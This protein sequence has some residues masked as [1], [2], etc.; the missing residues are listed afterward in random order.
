ME[1]RLFGLTMIDCRHLAF[2]L[3]EKNNLIH[4]FNRDMQM[5]GDWMKYF[6]SRHP[7][8]ALRKPEATFGA[9]AMGFN[10]SNVI[11]IF[12]F[13]KDVVDKH[14]LTQDRIY[15]SDET[16]ISINPKGHSK[17]IATGGKCQ[18]AALKSADRG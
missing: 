10:R 7:E 9:R 12:D 8:L 3:A 11:R 17:I 18:V 16:G 14:K 13:L 1:T 4:P 15:N 5:A 6:L 2:Q